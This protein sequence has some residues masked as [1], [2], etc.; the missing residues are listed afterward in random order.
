DEFGLTEHVNFG[1]IEAH[2]QGAVTSTTM[3]PNMWAFDH[4]AGLARANPTLAV[5][6][7]L[8]LTHG[9]PVLPPERV[10][11]LVDRDGQFYR[12][13]PFIQRLLRGQVRVDEIAA[14]CRAQVEKV[15]AA[16]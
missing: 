6:V 7:H 15:L 16:G 12:R 14:E 3:L 13:A 9:R 8:N 10:P 5:G 11:T 4:A 2:E 1:I